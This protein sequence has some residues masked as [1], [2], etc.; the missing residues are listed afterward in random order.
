MRLPGDHSLHKLSLLRPSSLCLSAEPHMEE[1]RELEALK[2]L[3][4]GGSHLF[5]RQEK[6]R[7]RSRG[8]SSLF[9]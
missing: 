2:A 5:P 4:L 1:A 7:P 8:A 9:S 6:G 3:L